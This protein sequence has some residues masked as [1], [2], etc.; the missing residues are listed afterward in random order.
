MSPAPVPSELTADRTRAL[1]LVDV[2]RETLARLDVLVEVLLLWQKK[3]NL[4]SSNTI[5]WLWTRHV[6]DSLQLIDLAPTALTWIDLGSGAGF[7]G[8]VIA[9]ALADTPGANV[10][11]IESNA[12]KAAFLREAVRV[13]GA[14]A[15]VHG[16]RIDRFTATFDGQPDAIT[17]RA[18]APLNTLLDQ[19]VALW[20][21]GTVGIFPK[22]QDVDAELTEAT[23][24]WNIKV[25]LV[26][27]RTDSHGRIVVVR[28]PERRIIGI[29][30][31]TG[32]RRAS[33]P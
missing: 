30:D 22:G 23:R 11:L 28:E 18:L 32:V 9:C 20:K 4:V 8:L 12:K 5:P 17:A 24:Y 7:P 27:S 25:N 21:T 31:A 13:T 16:E 1:R 19:S 6:A 15:R 2:S 26:P 33:K 29:A 10:H 3:T 14:P